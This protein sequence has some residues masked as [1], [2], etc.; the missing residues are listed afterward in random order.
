MRDVSK[1]PGDITSPQK[2]EAYGYVTLDEAFQMLRH[3]S[4]Q[5]QSDIIAMILG[6]SCKGKPEIAEIYQAEI[7]NTFSAMFYF[8]VGFHFGAFDISSKSNGELSWQE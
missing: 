2:G 3:F 5:K 7:A 8:R 1:E 4:W 6:L